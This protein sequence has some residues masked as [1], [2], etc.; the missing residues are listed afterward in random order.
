M[1]KILF[2]LA[3]LT[4]SISFAQ[5]DQFSDETIQKFADAYIDVRNENMTFQL[6]MVSAIEDAGLTNDEFTDIHEMMKNPNAKN[7]VT[8]AQK[9][10]YNQ[11]LKNIQNL[12]K[13]IQETMERLIEQN[14]LKLETYQAITKASMNNKTLKEKIQKLI[15]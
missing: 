3:I 1:K 13:D 14:G 15:Q 2:I 10:K 12:N 7:K 8:E 6:N 5:N 9:R 4:A 11:A